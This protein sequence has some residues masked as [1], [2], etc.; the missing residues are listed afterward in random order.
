MKSKSIF[1]EVALCTLALAL[2]G[3][4]LV[5]KMNSKSMTEEPK[6]ES[7][8]TGE[9]TVEEIAPTVASL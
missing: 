1:A 4:V 7:M 2:A 3:A 5:Q 6:M 9:Q 8:M